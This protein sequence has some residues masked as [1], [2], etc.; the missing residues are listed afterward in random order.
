[1]T[2]MVQR[3]GR[4]PNSQ[5]PRPRHRLLAHRRRRRPRRDLVVAVNVGQRVQPNPDSPFVTRWGGATEGV[6]AIIIP[7]E[8]RFAKP[9]YIVDLDNGLTKYFD[10]DELE[11]VDE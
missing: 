6:I 8:D 4:H 7:P 9:A 5:H 1:M 3:E 11:V 2:Q 10:P